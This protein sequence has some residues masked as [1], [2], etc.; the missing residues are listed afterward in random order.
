MFSNPDA[1]LN[2]VIAKEGTQMTFGLMHPAM[3][4]IMRRRSINLSFQLALLASITLSGK[5]PS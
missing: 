1:R 4:Q 2:A 3:N 5:S